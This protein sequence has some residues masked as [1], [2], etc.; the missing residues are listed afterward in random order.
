MRLDDLTNTLND[1]K[2]IFLEFGKEHLKRMDN[3]ESAIK[4]LKETDEEDQEEE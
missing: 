4:G 1:F 3:I 2:D